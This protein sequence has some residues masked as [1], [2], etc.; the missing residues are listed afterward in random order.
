MIRSALTLLL[1]ALAC[2]TIDRSEC[3]IWST[4]PGDEICE[5]CSVVAAEPIMLADGSTV[6]EAT[7]QGEP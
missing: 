6:V 7:C 5:A 4:E 3:A 1:A 2:D